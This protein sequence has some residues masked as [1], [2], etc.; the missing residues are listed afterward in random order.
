MYTRLLRKILTTGNFL[1]L[2]IV[3]HLNQ[4]KVMDIVIK[5]NL[6]CYL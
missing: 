5:G 2:D 3:N 6:I 1:D 4:E